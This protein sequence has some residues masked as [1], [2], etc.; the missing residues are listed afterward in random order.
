ML[1]KDI[2]ANSNE[3]EDLVRLI[4]SYE[5]PYEGEGAYKELW[6]PYGGHCIEFYWKK[7][8]LKKLTR[9]QKHEV[10]TFLKKRKNE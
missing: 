1:V 5:P 10:L 3:D 9:K 2:L 7:E 4:M 6:Y 8:E